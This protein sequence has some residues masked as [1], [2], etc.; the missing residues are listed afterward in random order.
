MSYH[1]PIIVLSLVALTLSLAAYLKE[2]FGPFLKQTLL[3][4]TIVPYQ[5]TV[6]DAKVA[7]SMYRDFYTDDA[8]KICFQRCKNEVYSTPFLNETMGDARLNECYAA[9]M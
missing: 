6:S 1:W 4:G 8:R 3:D 9:C 2:H 7:P 5:Y